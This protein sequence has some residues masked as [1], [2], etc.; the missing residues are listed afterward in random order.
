MRKT[1]KFSERNFVDTLRTAI[2]TRRHVVDWCMHWCGLD[3]V[4]AI[5]ASLQHPDL[6]KPSS[7][8][9]ISCSERNEFVA[10]FAQSVARR[11]FGGAWFVTFRGLQGGC[12]GVYCCHRVSRGCCIVVSFQRPLL[13]WLVVA[14]SRL[15]CGGCALPWAFAELKAVESK[16][17][18]RVSLTW[19]LLRRPSSVVSEPPPRQLLN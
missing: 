7:R 8:S 5:E 19:R 16:E 1:A 12:R 15:C 10:Y 6:T 14:L 13:A 17:F 4:H 11:P 9:L 2:C 18:G 3:N